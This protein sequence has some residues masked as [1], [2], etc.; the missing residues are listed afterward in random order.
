MV[1]SNTTLEFIAPMGQIDCKNAFCSSLFLDPYHL[2]GK[3]LTSASHIG[4]GH[5]TCFGQCSVG[6]HDVST[7]LQLLVWLFL[8]SFCSSALLWEHTWTSPQEEGGQIEQNQVA[9]VVLA[10]AKLDQPIACYD[11]RFIF[12]PRQQQ[13][14]YQETHVWTQVCAQAQVKS[15][16]AHTPPSEP[17]SHRSKT[18]VYCCGPLRFVVVCRTAFLWRYVSDIPHAEYTEE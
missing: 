5:V 4:R 6:F 2:S 8:H 7:G 18:N 10:A 16:S 13:P 3:A 9:L 12:Q 17:H 11:P 1:L 14:C 15:T